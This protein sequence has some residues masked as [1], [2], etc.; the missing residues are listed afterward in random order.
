MSDKKTPTEKLIELCKNPNQPDIATSL[1]DAISKGADLNI[2]VHSNGDVTYTPLLLACKNNA[3]LQFIKILLGNGADLNKSS[4]VWTPL[5]WLGHNSGNREY[6]EILS[7]FIHSDTLDPNFTDKD[8][9][10]YLYDLF[11]LKETVLEFINFHGHRLKPDIIN[12]RC[13]HNNSTMLLACCREYNDQDNIK[14]IRALLNLG[15]D[16]NIPG[17]GNI[18]D[19]WTPLAIIAHSDSISPRYRDD[20]ITLLINSDRLNPN[21]YDPRGYSYLYDLSE[22]PHLLLEFLIKKGGYIEPAIFNDTVYNDTNESTLLMFYCSKCT[23]LYNKILKAQEKSIVSTREE[24]RQSL[25]FSIDRADA[26]STMA[27][28]ADAAEKI[29]ETSIDTASLYRDIITILVTYGANLNIVDKTDRTALDY[30]VKSFPEVMPTVINDV[31]QIYYDIAHFLSQ[32]GA[33]TYELVK[34]TSTPVIKRPEFNNNNKG[35]RRKTRKHKG[36]KTRKYTK[37]RN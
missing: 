27:E 7:L 30:L 22:H 17:D 33:K 19:E 31:L 10:T 14:I 13:F 16:P 37:M 32:R 4:G 11:P 28:N 2:I 5:S 21:I 24:A 18:K 6:Y 35:G 25:R 1:L 36:K 8:G 23:I 3:G 29:W 9:F 20:I 34:L 26:E 12:A 15:A